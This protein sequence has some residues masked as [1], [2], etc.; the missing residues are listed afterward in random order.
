[1]LY[2]S[3][4]TFL[5]CEECYIKTHIAQDVNIAQLEEVTQLI[6]NRI[7]ETSFSDGD[8]DD[9]LLGKENQP[10][11]ERGRSDF[12]TEPSANASALASSHRKK[13]SAACR[14][15]A[16]N[17]F[18]VPADEQSRENASESHRCCHH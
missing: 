13:E 2:F 16:S 15:Q 6:V 5:R 14:V 18:I 4:S 17:L 12:V 3:Y 8:K 9:L 11:I 7:I 10:I 1:M